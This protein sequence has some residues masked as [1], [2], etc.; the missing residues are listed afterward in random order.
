[1]KS[2]RPHR[3][4]VAS[5]GLT[6]MVLAAGCVHKLTRTLV[7]PSRVATL[8]ARSPFL[9]AHM[10]DGSVYIL[11]EWAADSTNTGIS[12]SGHRLGLN[13]EPID[14]G[15]FRLATDSVVLFETNVEE[16]SGASAAITV[17]A[18]VTAVIAGICAADPKTCF[19]SCPTFYAPGRDGEMTLQAEGFSSSI[20]P[21]L[22]ATDVDMLL[23]ALP[24]GRDFEVHVTNEALETHVIRHA[25]L[26]VA[27]RPAD[28]RV[29]MTSSGV[30]HETTGMVP[31]SGCLAA[32]GDCLGNVL[33]ADGQ[34]RFSEADS[35]DLA[36]KETIELVFDHVP[37]GELGLVLVSRQ[38]FVTTFLIYQALAYLGSDAGR[39]M[40]SLETGGDEARARAGALGRILGGIEVSV[41]DDRGD[42]VS[43]GGVGETGP[44]AT[45]TRVVPLGVA[46]APLRVRLRLTRGLWRL[47]QAVL[48]GLGKPV[49]PER[50]RPVS[51]RGSE[52]ESIPA[53]LTA[54]RD[55]QKTLVTLPG[56]TY[57]VSYR[58]PDDPSKLELFLEAR[59]YY[60]EWMRQEWL[61]ERDP[62]RAAQL[63]LDPAGA[64]RALAPEFKRREAGFE[65]LFW[66]SRYV[67]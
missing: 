52:G 39:W 45:D 59:G 32:E 46:A 16:S 5:C 36:A 34:E 4:C 67:R 9:K 21:A 37:G 19:G 48:V 15:T 63:V 26:L 57:R 64:M 61:A 41:L 8:D 14:S 12:G 43:T 47:D 1:M 42:W 66:N 2:L 56:D 7:P 17:M 23:H 60:L 25:D 50:L 18:G 40:A 10:A 20:A 11:G 44:I 55:P 27:P 62:M 31:P 24:Q 38:T 29:F 65:H 13:R 51:V 54:L 53:A 35:T 22:E 49:T 6:A 33:E 58:L 30:F 28:G 3:L